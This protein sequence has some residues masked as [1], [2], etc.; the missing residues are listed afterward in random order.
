MGHFH[1]LPE[2]R[3][4]REGVSPTTP[5]GW[6]I[7]AGKPHECSSLEKAGRLEAA[8]SHGP[9]RIYGV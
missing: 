5:I 3:I 8:G 2:K 4:A 7:G 9:S 6:S 1:P